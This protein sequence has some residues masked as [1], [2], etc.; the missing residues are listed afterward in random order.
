M[1]NGIRIANQHEQK[2]PAA[3]ERN[4]NL[5]LFRI[6][7]ML[8]IVA[9][10]YVVNS[11]LC[12]A[13]GPI[14]SNPLAI[15]S[16]FLLLFGMWGKTGINCFVLITGY[17]MCKSNI[18]LKKFMK[19]L[20]EVYFYRIVFYVIFLAT[21]YRSFSLT[22]LLKV[23]FPVSGVADGFTSCYLLFFLFI[24]F[25]NI[26]IR[27]M[28]EKQH[29]LLIALCSF[30]YVILG[31]IPKIAVTMNYVSWFIVLYFIASYIR[32]YPKKW[33]ESTKIAGF[34]MLFFIVISMCSVVAIQWLS[35]KIGVSGL[36]YWF[37]VDSNKIL[38]V[39]TAVFA[40]CFFKNLKIKNSKFINTVAASTFGM[41]LIHANSDAMRQWL[42]K[43]TL[44][45]VGMYDSNLLF[46]H[47]FVSVIAIFIVCTIIDI[48]RRKLIEEPFFT[49]L[50][51]KGKFRS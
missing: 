7:V 43:D 30:I 20:L 21:G 39:L 38:A 51:K 46:V 44:N 34:A 48:I 3:K 26:L 29:I 28:T 17:F 13:N 15:K 32:L 2:S 31:T 37:V 42:W 50:M 47:A 18:T 33:F 12:A 36:Q 10:H 1:E 22:E 45:N 41:L 25:L 19:L 40:F 16:V 5:E 27:N 8:L 14:S 35:V 4:S 23:I 9:H 11:G 49:W 6:L 24:P